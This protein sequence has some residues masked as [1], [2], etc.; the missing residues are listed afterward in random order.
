MLRPREAVV[1]IEDINKN[2]EE[3]IE[4]KKSK[5]DDQNNDKSFKIVQFQLQV[6]TR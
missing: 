5:N 2:N 3:S 4:T 6:S 1:I